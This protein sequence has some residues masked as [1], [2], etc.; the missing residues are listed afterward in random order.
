[1]GLLGKKT[2]Y[3]EKRGWREVG[4]AVGKDSKIIIIRTMKLYGPSECN[5]LIGNKQ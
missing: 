1:M 3:V 5:L 4:Q 2:F